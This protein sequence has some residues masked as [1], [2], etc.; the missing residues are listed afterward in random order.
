MSAFADTAWAK[1]TALASTAFDFGA[2]V[3][4]GGGGGVGGRYT[5]GKIH[6]GGSPSLRYR[7]ELAPEELAVLAF[8][9]AEADDEEVM[10]IILHAISH[11]V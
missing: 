6:K 2:T 11:Y 10:Q 3:P 4:T 1:D 9:A 8:K 5:F 7:H